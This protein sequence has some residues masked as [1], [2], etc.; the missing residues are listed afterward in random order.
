MKILTLVWSIGPG[1]TERAAVNYAIGYQ[2][3]GHQSRVLVLGEGHERYKDL[4]SAGVDTTLLTEALH[5]EPIIINEIKSWAADIIHIHNFSPHLLLYINRLKTADTKVVETNVFSRPEYSKGY[6]A[7]N[8]SL[9]LTSW[10]FWRYTRRMRQAPHIPPSSVVPYIV[11]TKK[12]THPGQQAIAAFRQLHGIPVTAFVA[13][14]IGQAH[15]SKWSAE[16]IGVINA[17][18]RED[19]NIYYLL[20]GL[21]P[22]LK[23]TIQAQSDFFKS[24]VK[25]ID[26]IEGDGQLSL[27]YHSLDCFVHWSKIGESFGY[28]LTE[29]MLCG[30]PVVTMLTPFKDNGQFEVVGHQ[31]G[32][33]C[34][35][36]TNE[37]IHAILEIHNNN[38]SANQIKKQL[39][40][41]WVEQR[42]SFD[43]VMPGLIVMYESLLN[44]KK[45]PE[46]Y[47]SRNVDSVFLFYKAK[48][49]F[50]GFLI[51][52]VNTAFFFRLAKLV[53]I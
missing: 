34:V 3:Y 11:D 18:I 6:S 9:Q 17:T 48:S 19:N 43:A 44:K 29:A 14:R 41:G 46:N 33:I 20:T 8:L 16:L 31:Q 36:N 27:C 39:A 30:V 32:G 5:N 45:V 15:P 23:S 1:G 38:Q 37:F 26:R 2:K 51:R 50:K 4:V 53:I 52:L 22:A 35:T 42:F 21:P 47:N 49:F 7:V 40:E 12:F 10:G 24:R 28:V 25:C 13:G